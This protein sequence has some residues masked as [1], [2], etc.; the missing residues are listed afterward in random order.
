MEESRPH[1]EKTTAQEPHGAAWIGQL[2]NVI[3]NECHYAQR[4]SDRA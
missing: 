4:S 1:S 3:S 2:A